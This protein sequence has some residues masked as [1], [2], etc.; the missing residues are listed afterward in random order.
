MCVPMP[1]KINWYASI[2]LA[3]NMICIIV[4]QKSLGA[5]TLFNSDLEGANTLEAHVQARHHLQASLP[6]S[7]P[8]V[9]KQVPWTEYILC[10]LAC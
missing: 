1:R 10:L 8:A 9:G 5:A 3:I 4:S 6:S 7:G 2:F